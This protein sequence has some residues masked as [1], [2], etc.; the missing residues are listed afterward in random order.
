MIESNIRRF[1]LKIKWQ[2]NMGNTTNC[3]Q[4]GI[5]HTSVTNI[6][7]LRRVATCNNAYYN[8]PIDGVQS[9]IF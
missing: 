5:S 3:Y 1:L 6:N 9:I 2:T 7:K 4:D 8:L